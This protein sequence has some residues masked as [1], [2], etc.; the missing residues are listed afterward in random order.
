MNRS[1]VADTHIIV[2]SRPSGSKAGGSPG[3]FG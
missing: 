2:V 1:N 3:H